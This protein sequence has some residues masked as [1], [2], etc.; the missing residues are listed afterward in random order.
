MGVQASATV[1]LVFAAP[2][3]DWKSS[4]ELS[5]YTLLFQRYAHLA[6]S[7]GKTIPA[8]NEELEVLAP[9]DPL[10][11]F[12]LQLWDWLAYNVRQQIDQSCT[13]L[14]LTCAIG[15]KWESVLRNFK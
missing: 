6:L 9:P 14:H 11:L 5:A 12:V 15:R 3:L 8:V 2:F 10:L 1:L 7:K 13:R 4:Q